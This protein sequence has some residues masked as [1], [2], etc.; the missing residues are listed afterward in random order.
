[1]GVLQDIGLRVSIAS[2]SGDLNLNLMPLS[3]EGGEVDNWLFLFKACVR[4]SSFRIGASSVLK[5]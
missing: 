4:L 5:E 1:M 3:A 2:V